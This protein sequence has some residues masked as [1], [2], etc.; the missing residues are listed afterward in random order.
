MNVV[1]T[2]EK[3]DKDAVFSQYSDFPFRVSRLRF[4]KTAGHRT[5]TKAIA[6]NNFLMTL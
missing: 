1:G 2:G 6:G 4:L 5:G 3:A